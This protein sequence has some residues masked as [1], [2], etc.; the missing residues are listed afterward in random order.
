MIYNYFSRNIGLYT[1]GIVLLG[2][3]IYLFYYTIIQNYN[4]DKFDWDAYYYKGGEVASKEKKCIPVVS[5]EEEE[6]NELK[7]KALA[8]IK[9]NIASSKSN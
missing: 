9:K 3:V 2:L 8:E 4:R 6:L 7:S 1:T 5:A